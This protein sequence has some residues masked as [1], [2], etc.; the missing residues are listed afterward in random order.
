M[1]RSIVTLLPVVALSL[2]LSKPA[3]AG[4]P[5][6]SA[7]YPANPFHTDTKGALF[8]VHAFHHGVS[9][10]F[11]MS[12]VAEG[13]I[14]GRR[15]TVQLEVMPTYREG[16]FAVR[17]KGLEQGSWAVVV[18]M[19]DTETSAPASLIASVGPNGQLLAVSVPHKL[20]NGW[21]VP[22]KVTR[23][24]IEGALR[25][26]IAMAGTSRYA[27]N[28]VDASLAGF[29]LVGL[30]LFGVLARKRSLANR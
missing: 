3:S 7:E 4:P 24:D 22:R 5:W 18:T 20:E 23:E 15:Q 11:P 13:V 12:G 27:S 28:G 19:T 26:A 17:G 8:L 16:V 21:I 9:R 10:N 25:S 6:I 1:R 29:G 14:N 30:A 2:A